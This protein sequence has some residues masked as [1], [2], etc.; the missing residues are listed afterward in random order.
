MT[1]VNKEFLHLVLIIKQ[2]AGLVLLI[3]KEQ[4]KKTFSTFV[5]S[6]IKWPTSGSDVEMDAGDAAGFPQ[7]LSLSE[8]LILYFSRW[9]MDPIHEGWAAH[10][11]TVLHEKLV[12]L[13]RVNNSKYYL[14][15]NSFFFFN[16]NH[17]EQLD[18]IKGIQKQ[19]S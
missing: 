4:E 15:I 5:E 14:L 8:E 9:K 7:R 16:M 3:K 2:E 11:R 19:S 6:Q 10:R 1:G 12:G 17:C 18:L 13:L